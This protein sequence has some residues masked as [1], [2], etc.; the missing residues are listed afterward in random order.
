VIKEKGIEGKQCCGSDRA[1]QQRSRESLTI[2]ISPL[3]SI[4]LQREEAFVPG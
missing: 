4:A 1:E 2:I 3:P